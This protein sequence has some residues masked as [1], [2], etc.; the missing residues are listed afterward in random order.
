[1]P[2]IGRSPVGGNLNTLLDAITT[3]ARADF[4]LTKNSV[5]YNPISAQSLMVSL[6]GVTQAPIAAYT[7]SGN[8]ITFA[9]NLS[10]DDVIDYI[11][12]FEGPVKN[13]DASSIASGTLTTAMIEDDA[14]TADKLA[15]AINTSIAANTAKVTNATHTGDVTGATALTIA[16]DAVGADQM[17]DDAVGVA[18]LSAT[19]TAN[20]TTFL[21]G[22][23]TWAASGGLY[24]AWLVKTAD[25]YTAVSGDQLIAN[26][27]STAFTITLPASPSQGD[28]VV[29]KNVGA[30]LLTVGRN[31]EKIDS[32][33]E[34]ATMPTGNAVQ[35]VFT[36]DA[37]I[38][39]AIL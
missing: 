17:A 27:A 22:D 34:D 2:F 15:N 20:A 25:G 19:G 24:N 37:A 9:S 31:S 13:V 30:A 32:V 18:V 4:A 12:V 23:N 38:G 33:A 10:T 8:T 29:L 14:V 3:S 28:T 21:R 35:L 16:D 11:I 5:A 1:M 36:D 26:H 7:V 6:N 39:W